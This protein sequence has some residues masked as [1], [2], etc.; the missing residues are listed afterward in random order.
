MVKTND[1]IISEYEGNAVMFEYLGEIAPL[2]IDRLENETGYAVLVDVNLESILEDLEYQ[3]FSREQ[4][5]QMNHALYGNFLDIYYV[6]DY[7]TFLCV[8]GTK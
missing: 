5:K 1:F 3:G 6:T 4:L 2:D 8:I 7:S